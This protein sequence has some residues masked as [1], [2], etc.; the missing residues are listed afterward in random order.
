MARLTGLQVRPSS[1]WAARYRLRDTV[2]DEVLL[3]PTGQ[4]IAHYAYCIRRAAL[5]CSGKPCPSIGIYIAPAVAKRLRERWPYANMHG[6]NMRG[7]LVT[8]L[9]RVVG[10]LM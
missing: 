1:A 10:R 4:H 7:D 3:T 9:R 8:K 6:K 2:L 5:A